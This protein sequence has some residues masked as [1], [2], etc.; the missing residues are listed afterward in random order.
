[1]WIAVAAVAVGGE[2]YL[3]VTDPFTKI[4]VD[5]AVNNAVNYIE[6]LLN[7]GPPPPLNTPRSAPPNAPLPTIPNPFN[8]LH[9]D[10]GNPRGP[11]CG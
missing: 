3:Y 9:L 4:R 5:T 6:S 11:V 8:P 10:P 7:I 2:L 1:M